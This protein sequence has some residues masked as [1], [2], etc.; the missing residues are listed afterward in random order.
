M[1]EHLPGKTAKQIR[2]KRATPTYKRKKEIAPAPYRLEDIDEAEQTD[3]NEGIQE[4]VPEEADELPAAPGDPPRYITERT[5]QAEC[6][7]HTE[8]ASAA[9]HEAAWEVSV[10]E[11]VLQNNPP[12]AIPAEAAACV[13]LL[14]SSWRT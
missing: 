12:P 11:L 2:D 7:D 4:N 5:D 10:A 9:R 8:N 14:R 3:D 1:T 13:Q 6:A